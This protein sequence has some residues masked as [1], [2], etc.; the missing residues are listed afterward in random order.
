MAPAGYLALLGVLLF[1]ASIAI[2]AGVSGE[3]LDTDAGLLAQYADEGS[4]L[5]LA[6]VVYGIAWLCFAL[7]L[8]VLFTAVHAR[9]DRVRGVLVAFC[10][11]GPVLL[12]IQGPVQAIGLKD[13]GEKFVEQEPAAEV[14]EASGAEDAAAE[15]AETKPG[16]AGAADPDAGAGDQAAGEVTTTPT[17]EETP[18]T[19]EEEGDEENDATEQRAEDQIEDASLVSFSRALLLPAL[20]GLVLVMVYVPRW[21]M[22]TGLM[23]RFWAS[24]G[25]ALGVAV[26]LLPFAQL[27]LVI[28]FAALGLLLIDRWPRGRPPAWEAGTA[29]PWVRPGDDAG[30]TPDDAVEGSGREVSGGEPGE[31]GPPD[32]PGTPDGPDAGPGGQNGTGGPDE[33][34]KRKRR[35]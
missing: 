15:K 23:T 20:L 28:W 26:L 6:R 19:T 9:S 27:A 25:M 10:F 35:R 18:T 32:A 8:Y 1:V 14:A 16:E 33:P 22:R 30:G 29:I 5:V 11:I 17:E 3:N 13:A 31:L 7:P 34:R 4:R 24:L 21:A 2:Q 12:A